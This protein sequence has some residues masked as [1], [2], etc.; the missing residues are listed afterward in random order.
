V[1]ERVKRDWWRLRIQTVFRISFFL[2]SAK[3]LEGCCDPPIGTL[4]TSVLVIAPSSSRGLA[5]CPNVSPAR[6]GK[7][8]SRATS[9]SETNFLKPSTLPIE[10]HP[11]RDPSSVGPDREKTTRLRLASL[12]LPLCSHPW[13]RRS[14]EYCRRF[15]PD[16]LGGC[17]HHWSLSLSVSMW[18]GLVVCVGLPVNHRHRPPPARVRQAPPFW[19][20]HHAPRSLFDD[21]EL[22]AHRLSDCMF[23]QYMLSPATSPPAAAAR[24]FRLGVRG[25]PPHPRALLMTASLAPFRV[26]QLSFGR[27]ASQTFKT[28]GSDRYSA[29]R[30]N[31]PALTKPGKPFVVPARS[32]LRRNGGVADFLGSSRRQL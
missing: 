31:N 10:D 13:W 7:K 27:P 14:S 19:A 26:S 16:L 4:L 18:S 9:G 20:S 15:P 8:K 17:K 32:K 12:Q 30:V 11:K 1:R 25:P 22:T 6:D 2:Y 24:H 5:A 23:T 3:T 21:L 29:C 28:R